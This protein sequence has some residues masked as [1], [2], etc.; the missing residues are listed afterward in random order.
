MSAQLH[1]D[2]LSGLRGDCVKKMTNGK[3]RMDKNWHH[4]GKM[5]E[6]RNN[7]MEGHFQTVNAE[8]VDL[9]FGSEDAHSLSFLLAMAV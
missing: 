4:V 2:N 1:L 8:Y 9:Y 5:V 6:K 3:G 7:R